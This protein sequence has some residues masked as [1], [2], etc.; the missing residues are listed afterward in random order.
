MVKSAIRIL[1]FSAAL[2]LPHFAHADAITSPGLSD[3]M[4]QG[5]GRGPDDA[6]GGDGLGTEPPDF[7]QLQVI[8]A[9]TGGDASDSKSD[10]DTN[11]E[12]RDQGLK[13]AAMSFGAR[14]GL[15]SRTYQIRKTLQEK[16]AYL[17]SIYDFKRLL[18]TAPSGLLIEPPIISEE[19]DAMMIDKGGQTAAVSD[20]IYNIN[21]D[22]KIVSSPR[23][24]RA[25]LERDWGDVTPP[26][27]VLYPTTPAEKKIWLATLKAGW[28]E[29]TKQANEVFQADLDRLNADFKGMV[30]YRMLLAQGVVSAPYTLQTDRGV[31]GGGKEMRVGDRALQI[32][33]PSELQPRPYEWQPAS[34]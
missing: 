26:P 13:D 4:N 18:I 27:A 14:G 6:I 11:P 29:G 19:E 8:P 10:S 21:V 12:I 23:N 20:R 17:D 7:D 3:I 33:G 31:T 24:W 34:R 30:R 32:T 28:D 5:I 9:P 22:A 16:G 1:L 2:T 15:A 25:Y